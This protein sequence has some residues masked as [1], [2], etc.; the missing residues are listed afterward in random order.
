ML[1]EN[2]FQKL[3]MLRL[4]GVGAVLFLRESA[5]VAGMAKFQ[6]TARPAS[7]RAGTSPRWTEFAA[8]TADLAALMPN[9]ANPMTER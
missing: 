3:R 8:L 1:P 2:E 7:K 9:M 4:P 6:E 5:S